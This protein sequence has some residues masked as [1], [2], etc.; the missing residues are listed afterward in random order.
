MCCGRVA[1]GCLGGKA[2]AHTHT[3]THKHTIH[4]HPSQLLRSVECVPLERW[5]EGLDL[6]N[7]EKRNYK[8]LLTNYPED[9]CM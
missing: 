2:R 9:V 6:Y 5:R 4:A 3:H 1:G 8:V 7:R